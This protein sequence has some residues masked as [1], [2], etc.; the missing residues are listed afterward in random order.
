LGGR[1]VNKND[2]WCCWNVTDESLLWIG[3]QCQNLIE[4]SIC[5]CRQVTNKGL[6][7][8]LKSNRKL[9]KLNCVG[10]PVT[11]DILI[12]TL[13]VY[14][15]NIQ[16]LETSMLELSDE[17]VSTLKNKCQQLIYFRMSAGSADEFC[18]INVL[19]DW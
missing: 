5:G 2:L 7:Y 8:V 18:Q 16:E 19:E 4:F 9:R 3:L 10:T 14:N 13:S 1:D 12:S 6:C 11:T 17:C 15:P